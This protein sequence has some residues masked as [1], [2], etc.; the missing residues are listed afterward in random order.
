MT[1]RRDVNVPGTIGTPLYIKRMGEL[2][3]KKIAQVHVLFPGIST[4]KVDWEI[5]VDELLEPQTSPF[6]EIIGDGPPHNNGD[7]SEV[8]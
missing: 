8:Q 1:K 6:D 4:K 2:L 5:M 3:S 7:G